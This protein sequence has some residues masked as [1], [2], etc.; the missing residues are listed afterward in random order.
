M[1]SLSEHGD[2]TGVAA[3]LSTAEGAKSLVEGCARVGDV[4]ILVNNVGYFEV[5]PF[6]DIADEDWLAMFELN[7]MSGVRLTRALIPG[8]IAARLGPRD[9]HRQRPE[10]EAESR[11]CCTTR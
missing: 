8:M 3:D 10:R 4:D 11:R 1:R 7:V 6:T 2:V 9:L 5:K